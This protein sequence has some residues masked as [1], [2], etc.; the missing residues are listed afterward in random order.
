MTAA[1]PRYRVVALAYAVAFMNARG[2]EL[3][4]VSEHPTVE[5]AKAEAARLNARWE[6]DRAKVLAGAVAQEW[7]KRRP[8]RRFETEETG[9]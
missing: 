5:T 1:A 3:V 7:P 9:A 6:A 8:V 4:A 2:D